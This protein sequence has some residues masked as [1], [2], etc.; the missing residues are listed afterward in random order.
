MRYRRVEAAAW[1]VA[2]GLGVLGC[3]GRKDVKYDDPGRVETL[4]ED[5]GST[6]LQ[7]VADRMV[8]SLVRHPV[9]ASGNRPV[10]QVSTLRNSTSEHIDTK[11]V[12]DK[13]RTALIKSQMVR[14]TAV[15]DQNR[16]ILD[17]LDYQEGRG[18]V[19]PET[20]KKI[21][22]QVGADYL[23]YGDIAS[24]VKKAGRESDVYYKITLNLV[25]IESGIIEWS[26]EKEIR[27]TAKRPLFGS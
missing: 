8:A 2:I 4:T 16:E 27:K 25:D 14:F 6:D 22:R 9:I 12:T 11:S 18:V 3:S 24:I 26:D 7:S 20:A 5:W 19:S 17:N 21:G 1:A 15:S 13:I 23:L 10:L